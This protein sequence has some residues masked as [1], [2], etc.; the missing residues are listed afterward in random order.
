MGIR[1]QRGFVLV[2]TIWVLAIIAIA[3]AFFADRVERARDLAQAKQETAGQLLEFANTR[4]EILFRLGT[5]PFSFQGL[6]APPAAIALDGRPYRGTGKDIVRLQDNLGLLNVN[7]VHRVLMSR[8]LG[9]RGVPS[10]WHDAMIDGLLDYTDA[11]DLRR[12]SGADAR[13]YADAGLPPPPNVF[14]ETPEQLRNIIGWRDRRELW[15]NGGFL[16]F[17]TANRVAG[18]NLNT[19]P[20]EVLAALPGMTPE[21]AAA[22]V[23]LR[24][25]RPFYGTNDVPG[26]AAGTLEPEFFYFFPGTSLRITQ[27]AGKLPWALEMSLLLTPRGEF[28]PWRVDYD[29][30]TAVSYA[31]EN[32]DKIPGLPERAATA[33]ANREAP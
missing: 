2:A 6:G 24:A 21:S 22:L 30:R 3:A 15:E 1:A 5:T 18:L 13:E 19:A 32:E 26:Y 12:L 4:A 25:Q 16:R 14:L 9:Q 10:E 33:Q 20:P 27:Q 29:L 8:F 23:G 11:D 28:A 31:V 7:Y 17:L